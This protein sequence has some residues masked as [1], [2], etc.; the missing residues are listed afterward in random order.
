MSESIVAAAVAEPPKE[1]EA[2]SEEKVSTGKL[3]FQRSQ[4][5]QK[6]RRF[7]AYQ[8]RLTEQLT[9]AKEDSTEEGK[10]KSAKVAHQLLRNFC[11]TYNFITLTKDDNRAVIPAD[12]ASELEQVLTDKYY[13]KFEAAVKASKE[14]YEKELPDEVSSEVIDKL[15]KFV[16]LK[17]KDHVVAK[18]DKAIDELKTQIDARR[19]EEPAAKPTKKTSPRQ[20]KSKSKSKKRGKALSDSSKD[21]ETAEDQLRNAI[22][23]ISGRVQKL[24]L[25]KDDYDTYH[26]SQ[27]QLDALLKETVDDILK[28]KS[29]LVKRFEKVQAQP[30]KKSRRGRS[31]PRSD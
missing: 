7:S 29:K 8:K 22:K 25:N 14:D 3:R 23:A 4:Y 30:V 12:F 10:A 15:I 27:A 9:Q 2:S 20:T 16:Q 11:M 1:A 17:E 26:S 6:A 5:S 24:R 31:R 28:M 13:A 18:F 19:S 21:E